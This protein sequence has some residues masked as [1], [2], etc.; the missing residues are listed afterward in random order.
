MASAIRSAG[1]LIKCDMNHMNVA[2]LALAHE[3]IAAAAVPP[4]P[5]AESGAP[6]PQQ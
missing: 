3:R 1:E 4:A 6:I 5:A 2:D